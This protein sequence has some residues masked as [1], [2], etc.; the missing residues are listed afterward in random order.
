MSRRALPVLLP[1]WFRSRPFLFV[2]ILRWWNIHQRYKG[3]FPTSLALLSITGVLL[4]VPI[5][6]RALEAAA[7]NPIPPFILMAMA[8]AIAAA[9]RKTHLYRSLVDSWLAPL[10]APTSLL[11]RALLPP[12]MQVLLLLWVVA[13]PVMS[14]SLSRMAARTLC[15]VIIAAYVVGSEVGWLSLSRHN[16]AMSSPGFHYVTIRKPRANWAQESRLEPLSYL[17][18]GQ[19]R[20]F[21]KPNMVAKVMLLVLMAL[22]LG[23]SGEQALT[24]AAGA[25]VSLYVGSLILAPL[26]AAFVAARWLGPTPIRYLK[27]S[28][29]LGYRALLAQAWTWSWLLFLGYAAGLKGVL[30]SGFPLSLVSLSVASVIIAGAARFAMKS[31]GMMRSP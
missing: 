31:V 19:A 5:V 25:W 7:Q 30:R 12:L 3:L 22:P 21:A 23:I 8:C 24:I 20:V 2:P 29:T 16:K 27:F 26:P 1:R 11:T 18:V 9:R 6:G 13:I 28:F 17:A 10:G 15:A 4:T 14:G